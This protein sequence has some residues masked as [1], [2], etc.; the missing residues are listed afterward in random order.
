VVGKTLINNKWLN[1][2][3]NIRVLNDINKWIDSSDPT[4]TADSWQVKLINTL[5]GKAGT[6]NVQKSKY[7]YDKDTTDYIQG[8]ENSLKAAIKK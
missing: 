7:F 2:I 6:Y 5:I 8:L 1:V 3:R 4:K